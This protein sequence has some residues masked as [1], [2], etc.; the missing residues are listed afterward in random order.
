MQVFLVTIISQVN[1]M[2]QRILYS[3]KNIKHLLSTKK[4]K[5]SVLKNSRIFLN[6]R[7]R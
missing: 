3:I 7:K 6:E 5:K 1:G 2:K 4:D